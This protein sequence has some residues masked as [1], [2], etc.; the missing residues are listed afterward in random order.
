MQSSFQFSQSPL[1]RLLDPDLILGVAT[2]PFLAG[3]VATQSITASLQELGMMSEEI[4]RG[5]RLPILEFP[6][7]ETEQ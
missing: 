5:D 7:P 1:S 3:L 4:F 6:D 2:L